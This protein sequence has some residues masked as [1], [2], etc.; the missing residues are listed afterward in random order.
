M[1][2]IIS[3]RSRTLEE[4]IN[5]ALIIDK[6]AGIYK[7]SQYLYRPGIIRVRNGKYI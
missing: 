2:E 3:Q 6:E 7:S 5:N 1:S 4:K